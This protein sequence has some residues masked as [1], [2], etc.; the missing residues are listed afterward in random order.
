MPG[1]RGRPEGHKLS[2]E[3]KDKIRDGRLGKRHTQETRD[4]ISMS[5]SKE[6][7]R[8]IISDFVSFA[9]T[10]ISK[11]KGSTRNP[12]MVEIIRAF[13]KSH[14]LNAKAVESNIKGSYSVPMRKSLEL[15]GYIAYASLNTVD[16][17]IRFISPT[18]LFPSERSTKR[19]E[20]VVKEV[21]EDM[22]RNDREKERRKKKS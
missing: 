9:I 7:R 3:S 14:G 22:R 1:K 12:I 4:K 13:V 20:N 2:Q 16:R 11:A 15:R 19:L 10:Y 5:L 8:P 18:P 21:I 6:G 17:R